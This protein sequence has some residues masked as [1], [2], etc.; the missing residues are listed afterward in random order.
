MK[1]TDKELVEMIAQSLR[2]KG[3]HNKALDVIEIYDDV[4]KSIIELYA[5]LDEN[6]LLVREFVEAH[7]ENGYDILTSCQSRSDVDFFIK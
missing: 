6:E 7:G 3:E 5:Y 1:K 4:F 2:D